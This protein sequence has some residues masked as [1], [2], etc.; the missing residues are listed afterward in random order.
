MR[1]QPD[2]I[3]LM[4]KGLAIPKTDEK[5]VAR[6]SEMA[7]QN[8]RRLWKGIGALRQ[9]RAMFYIPQ[10]RYAVMASMVCFFIG[11]GMVASPPTKQ[12]TL[13]HEA[14]L[15]DVDFEEEHWAENLLNEANGH[16]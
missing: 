3:R 14:L 8:P 9:F 12:P 2:D 4:L 11:I 1:E 13:T 7:R 5:A 16:I 6:I 15:F 10:M